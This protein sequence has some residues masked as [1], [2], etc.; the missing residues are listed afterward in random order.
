MSEVYTILQALDT[1]LQATTTLSEVKSFTIF[2]DEIELANASGNRNFPFIN[3]N[4]EIK[5]TAGAE[6]L[7]TYTY[8]R[9]TYTLIVTFAVREKS[10]SAAKQSIWNYAGYIE[11]AY[12]ADRSIGGT[13]KETSETSEIAVDALKYKATNEWIGRGIIEFNVSKDEYIGG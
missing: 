1:L 9:R 5:N 10:K 12:K 8:E 6:N 11:D 2:E 3:L 13:V 4:S 7:P